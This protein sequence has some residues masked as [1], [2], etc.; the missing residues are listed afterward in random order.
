MIVCDI[1]SECYRLFVFPQQKKKRATFHPKN[2]SVFAEFERS[3][4]TMLES[5]TNWQT[6]SRV[7]IP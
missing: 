3:V 2:Q 5:Q 7:D 4:K 6:N 1:F